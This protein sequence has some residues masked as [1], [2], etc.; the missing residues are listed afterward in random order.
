VKIQH[1]IEATP[2]EAAQEAAQI[3]REAAQ[4]EIAEGLDQGLAGKDQ[5][6][7]DPGLASDGAGR[8]CS[9]SQAMCAP[10]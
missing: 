1:Q 6:F 3:A 8:P 9:T 10:G 7:V 4:L 2:A 5:D